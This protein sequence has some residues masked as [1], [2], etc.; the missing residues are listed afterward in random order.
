MKAEKAVEAASAVA[1]CSESQAPG[2]RRMNCSREPVARRKS[3]SWAGSSVLWR[4]Q[5]F[6]SSARAPAAADS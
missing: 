5:A 3:Y 1:A 6:G 4:S 2:E